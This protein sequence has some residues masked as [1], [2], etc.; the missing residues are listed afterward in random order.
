MKRFQP[1][2]V[3]VE[4]LFVNVNVKTAWPSVRLGG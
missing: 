3:A 4:E 2:A 1:D